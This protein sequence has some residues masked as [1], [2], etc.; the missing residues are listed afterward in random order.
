MKFDGIDINMGCPDRDVEKQGAGAALIKNPNLAKQI[1]RATKKGAGRMPVS[2]KTRIGY[3]KDQIKEW[4]QV[5][6][7]KILMH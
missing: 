4:I 2:V 7:R 3:G 1:I 5:L 6:L